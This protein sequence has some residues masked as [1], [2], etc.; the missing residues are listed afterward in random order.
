MSCGSA[1]RTARSSASSRSSQAP[2][3]PRRA[4]MRASADK[5]STRCT[6]AVPGCETTDVADS[7]ASSYRPESSRQAANIPSMHCVCTFKSF[8]Y[9]NT[10]AARACPSA[11]AGSRN[12]TKWSIKLFHARPGGVVEASC[13]GSPEGI[14]EGREP[15]EVA[16]AQLLGAI[17]REQMDLHLVIT[18]DLGDLEPPPCGGEARRALAAHHVHLRDDAV[19]GVRARRS[20]PRVRGSRSAAR[21]AASAASPSFA[22]RNTSTR[23]RND[24]PRPTRSPA[25]RQ[26]ESASVLASSASA[27]RSTT[28]SSPRTRRAATLARPP[29]SHLRTAVPAR[30]GLRF[31]RCAP[32][33]AAR[34]AASGANLTT[35]PASP[36]SSA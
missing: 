12:R 15:R 18:E 3:S 2:G 20:R 31:S 8:E 33:A 16:H 21:P 27:G 14:F 32:N 25:S 11:T 34:R 36:A 22:S 1:P 4:R 24:A 5:G 7:I 13:L 9:A 19:R 23:L 28:M 35:A 26:H 29:A 17:R 10:S 30:T 6:A